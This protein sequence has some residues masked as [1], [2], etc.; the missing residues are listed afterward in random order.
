MWER[1]EHLHCSS[2]S[3]KGTWKQNQVLGGILGHP[4]P[5]GY[6]QG[7]LALQVERVSNSIQNNM[8]VNPVGLESKKDCTGDARHQLLSTDINKQLHQHQQTSTISKL[9]RDWTLSR[10]P[11]GCMTPRQ[12]ARLSVGRN[13]ILILNYWSS[14]S[15][16]WE[17]VRELIENCCGWSKGH[18]GNPEKGDRPPFE[19]VTRRMAKAVAET[20]KSDYHCMHVTIC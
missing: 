16:C 18:F 9:S 10:V 3:R 15:G 6:K 7:D 19:A 4:V 2:V 13:I 20:D 12:N 5:G 17:S 11:E 14:S 1:F 8:V